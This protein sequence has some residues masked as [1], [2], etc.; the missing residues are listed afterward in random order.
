M[1]KIIHEI[2]QETKKTPEGWISYLMLVLLLGFAFVLPIYAVRYQARQSSGNNVVQNEQTD[3]LKQAKEKESDK[4]TIVL[5]P[6]H[7][8]C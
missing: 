1:K 8:G 7:G 5:D 6:G 2:I 3:I 4:G